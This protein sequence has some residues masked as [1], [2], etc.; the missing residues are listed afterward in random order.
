MLYSC[1]HMAMVGIKGLTPVNS[2]LVSV[3]QIVRPV[4]VS[5]CRLCNRCYT[6]IDH[7]CLYLY[8][9]VAIGNHRLFVLFT[10]VVMAAMLI[11]EYSCVVYVQSV[12]AGQALTD[13]SVITAVFATC[14]MMWSLFVL[15]GMSA[16]WTAW[17]LHTQIVAVSKGQLHAYQ[18]YRVRSWLSTRQRLLNIVQFFLNRS[19]P[20]LR[21]ELISAW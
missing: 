20:R 1:S 2:Q 12:Y 10:A 4:N 7:H 17:V 16:V 13:W 9:C 14:P 19:P 3:L 8:R 11:F 15:N 18:S 5:H 6:Q 21:D